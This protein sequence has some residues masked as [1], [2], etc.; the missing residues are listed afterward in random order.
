M[1]NFLNLIFRTLQWVCPTSPAFESGIMLRV[2]SSSF[3]LPFSPVWTLFLSFPCVVSG[4]SVKDELERMGEGSCGPV[5]AKYRCANFKS[6]LTLR[7]GFPEPLP[8]KGGFCHSTYNPL[9]SL[10]SHPQPLPTDVN[11]PTL[12]RCWG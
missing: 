3:F 7:E 6:H 9:V 1:P 5:Y 12:I 11:T 2:L 8:F 10:P 4:R